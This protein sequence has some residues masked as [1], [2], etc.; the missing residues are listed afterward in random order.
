ME[1]LNVIYGLLPEANPRLVFF[2]L[3][4]GSVLVYILNTS[5]STR[6]SIASYRQ[7]LLEAKETCPT[8]PTRAALEKLLVDPSPKKQNF[9]DVFSNSGYS[10]NP[11]NLPDHLNGKGTPS[12]RI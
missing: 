1:Y 6:V 11:K 3:F 2:S 8:V 10:P 7:T 9:Y 4:T 12:T 5:T